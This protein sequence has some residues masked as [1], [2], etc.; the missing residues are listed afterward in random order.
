MH[1][2]ID[3]DICWICLSLKETNYLNLMIIFFCVWEL[4][5]SQFFT[6][7]QNQ[8]KLLDFSYPINENRQIKKSAVNFDCIA[9]TSTEWSY[10]YNNYFNLKAG[11]Y[12][13]LK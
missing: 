11:Q 3:T 5:L 7:S 13:L 4:T 2:G 12:F 6:I 8:L 10:Y 1:L 9:L